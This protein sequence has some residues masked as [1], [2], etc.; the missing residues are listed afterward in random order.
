M[1]SYKRSHIPHTTD[2]ATTITTVRQNTQRNTHTQKSIHILIPA[3]LTVVH[4]FIT[5]DVADVCAPPRK[6]MLNKCS[7]GLVGM[8]CV[9]V[10]W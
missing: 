4:A 2:T 9:V 8:V 5:T 7:V 10:V 3:A 6:G 1:C